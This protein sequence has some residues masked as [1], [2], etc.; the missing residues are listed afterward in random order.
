MGIFS[1]FW[2][3]NVD[4]S[5]VDAQPGDNAVTPQSPLF[6]L[7]PY[8]LHD[9]IAGR[10]EIYRILG[11]PG[12]SGMGIVYVCYDHEGKEVVAL[13]TFQ[14]KYLT[15]KKARDSFKR[16]ALLWVMLERH[17][18]IV[19]AYLAKVLDDR[20][21]VI[22]EFVAPD[23]E[24]RNTLTHY[25]RQPISL[26]QA[27][28]WSIQF[29]YGMEYMV[30]K[31]VTPH[32]NIKP[33]NIL[34]TKDGSL[35]ITGFGLA[36]SWQREGVAEA[37]TGMVGERRESV[38]FLKQ[39]EGKIV[40]GTPPWMA[41]EQFDGE[42]DVRSDLY[43]F[44]IVLYQMAQDGKLPL[45]PQ[46]GDS[47]E[48]A[49][50]MY[51]LR[52]V[53][54][55]SGADA[56]CLLFPL[57]EKCL[58]KDRGKRYAGF[59]ELRQ[60]LEETYRKEVTR[61][62]GEELPLPPEVTELETEELVNKGVSLFNLGLYDEAIRACREA[63]RIRPELADAHNNLGNALAAK[64]NLDGAIEKCRE[65]LRFQPNYAEAHN[66]LAS[67]L[68]AKGDLD[69]AIGE[70]RVALRIRPEYAEAHYNLAVALDDKRDL[71][72]AIE[73]YREALKIRPDFAGAHNNLGIALK[74]KGD[75]DGAIRAFE[76]FIRYA[77][78][79]YAGQVEKAKQFI[80]E[81]NECRQLSEAI[82]NENHQTDSSTT[83]V[84][85][86]APPRV[87]ERPAREWK[88]GDRIANRYQIF[89]IVEGGMGILYFC[90]DR[91]AREPV[92]I[93]TFKERDG[94]NLNIIELFRSEALTWVR[95]G[96]HR[97]VVQ[98]KYVVDVEKRPYVFLEYIASEGETEPSLRLLLKKG[99]LETDRALNLSVQFCDGMIHATRTIPGLIHRDIKP[100]NILVTQDEI[101]KITDFGL[102]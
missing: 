18:Y 52:F 91:Q 21:F 79:Q 98:A 27:L 19:Q 42:A 24:G 46:G 93:R 29:C 60:D 71:D 65:A 12:K 53:Q 56:R 7:Q 54:P 34:I 28:I 74:A 1:S 15:F 50:N 63:L 20:L 70:Y 2:K 13:K 39:P 84:S 33:D 38:S 88:V 86:F 40:G 47:W 95:L 32:R 26:K 37:L 61:K 44:G 75:V 96:K 76:D 66:N 41:P 57:I 10:Y 83:L 9:R 97:N 11:G 94:L 48:N 90:Y 92:A 45:R 14:D 67:A 73:E 77:P 82:M 43:S 17:P 72:R 81:I 3:K 78:P 49:H 4:I 68:K 62:T 80:A 36:G 64:G 51:P 101:L 59:G 5:K 89:R 69:G 30:M 99:K 23:D 85:T 100:E 22:C 6:S 25:L 87:I 16:E 55:S 35:K 8:N 58:A 102:T 31:G